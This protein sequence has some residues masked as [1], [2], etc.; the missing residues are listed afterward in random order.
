MNNIHTI[1]LN[2]QG[3]SNTIG[4]YLIQSEDGGVLVE[5]GPGS[6][7][8]SL[9]RGISAY[10]LEPGDI[11]DVFLTHIHLD[12]AGSAGWW[13]RNGA[14][15]H[16]H[17]VGAPH[18]RNP[19]KLLA[20]AERIYGN[21]MRTLWGDFHPVP[22]ELINPLE[23]NDLIELN[24]LTLR[25]LDTPGHANHHISYLLDGVCFCGDVGGVHVHGIPFVRLPSVPPEFDPVK[26]RQ[27]I[28]IFKSEDIMAFAPTHFGIHQDAAWHLKA[29]EQELDELLNWMEDIMPSNP[30]LQ[31]VRDKYGAWM[32]K[33]SDLAGLSPEALKKYNIAISSEM[34]ADGIFRY[35]NKIR[36]S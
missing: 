19:E 30:T 8:P 15:I 12:H 17:S 21:Q 33:R 20:S 13:A 29:L 26:W 11:T 36:N 5:C 10:N 27:S 25:A 4:V 1:D 28:Q 2:F 3:I 23:D 32:N 6:T 14:R 34:S 16:V 35:W 7:L 18:L 24:G 31:I 22:P 9:I